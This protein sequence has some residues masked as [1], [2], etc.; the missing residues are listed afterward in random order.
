MTEGNDV[1]ITISSRTV[2]KT[3]LLLILVAFLFYVRDI[4]LVVLAAIVIASAIEPATHWCTKHRIKRLPAVIG[5]YFI[6]GLLL[7]LFF[8]FFLPSVLNEALTY[9]N[10]LPEKINLSDIWEPL[11]DFTFFAQPE[12]LSVLPEKTFSIKEFIEASKYAISGTGA[13]AFKTASFIFGGALS[14]TL[15][16]VLSFYL[17]VQEDGVGSFLK[18]VTPLKH[19]E[20]IIN[21]WKRSQKK[22]G[23]W[24]Q[25]QLL[26]ALIVGILVYLGLTVLGIEHA[27]LLASVAA[28]LEIIPIFGPIISLVPALLIALVGGGVTPA[29][30]VIVLYAIIQQF[31]N[32]LLYPLVVRKIVGIS[33]MVVIL[34]LVIGA[35]LAGFL[36]AIL[37]V[38]VASA[39]MEWID[40]LEKGKHSSGKIA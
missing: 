40:D 10:N 35:K 29:I 31:E 30:L 34:A 28:I 33:P 14:F 19:H 2:I 16:L 8:I 4:V 5:I 26:L 32:H 27:L 22:I 24:M 25:G 23:Y 21:L 11:R 15:M 37:A 13:G 36:G 17:A 9:L 6:L 12:A 38:P 7:S 3:I 1:R 20:Y 18:I 39:L